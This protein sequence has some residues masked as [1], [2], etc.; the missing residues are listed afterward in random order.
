MEAHGR[1][2]ANSAP[3]GTTF[4]RKGIYWLAGAAILTAIVMF[5]ATVGTTDGGDQKPSDEVD[6]G[7]LLLLLPIPLAAWAWLTREK[8]HWKAPLAYRVAFHAAGFSVAF[9]LASVGLSCTPALTL[10]DGFRTLLIVV[11][12]AIVV[13]FFTTARLL[14]LWS[15]RSS[16]RRDAGE[17]IV[18][19]SANW[20]LVVA[21]LGATLVGAE[22][23]EITTDAIVAA[24]ILMVPFIV[25]I[26]WQIRQD[27]AAPE[28]PAEE[29]DLAQDES[30]GRTLRPTGS[31]RMGSLAAHLVCVIALASHAKAL[32]AR[33][34]RSSPR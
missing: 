15:R 25:R 4:F 3:A 24:S 33:L 34:G 10:P 6:P 23:A 21:L 29:S 27:D 32:A 19:V 8:D 2:T 26:H 11:S 9:M 1:L 16:L 14:D 28:V 22:A 30:D 13:Q 31:T 7:A 17:Y 18:I 5:A 12:V 20:A